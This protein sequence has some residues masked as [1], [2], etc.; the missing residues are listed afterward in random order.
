[1]TLTDIKWW[2]IG[3]FGNEPNYYV[4]VL[5]RKKEHSI[6]VYQLH[7]RNDA[8]P[9]VGGGAQTRRK[10][11]SLL[12][13]WERSASATEAEAQRLYD[14]IRESYR[15]Q[16]IGPHTADY[17]RLLENEPVDVGQDDAG[18]FERVINVE[19]YYRKEQ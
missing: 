17:V 2:L 15:G 11:V 6:G 10:C 18:V 8:D 9:H 1:M 3:L 13:H 12:V 7:R 16:P 19:I 14:M 5:D 4:G